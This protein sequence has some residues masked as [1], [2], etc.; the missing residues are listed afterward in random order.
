[1]LSF[2]EVVEFVGLCVIFV[3]NGALIKTSFDIDAVVFPGFELLPGGYDSECG[4][5]CFE[6]ELK[7]NA[8][9]VE[10]TTESEKMREKKTLIKT[11][12]DLKLTTSVARWI[13]SVIRSKCT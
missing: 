3:L 2:D 13:L 10:S 1:M 8:E 11:Q 12:I 4:N 5:F 7:L 9:T 6:T